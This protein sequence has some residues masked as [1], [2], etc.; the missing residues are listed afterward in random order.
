MTN[1]FGVATVAQ[2]SPNPLFRLMNRVAGAG[3]FG[4]RLFA[5]IPTNEMLVIAKKR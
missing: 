2:F 1:P 3:S 5:K 4:E